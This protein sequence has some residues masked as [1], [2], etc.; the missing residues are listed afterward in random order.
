MLSKQ[1]EE[2]DEILKSKSDT[3]DEQGEQILSLQDE[4]TQM[5]SANIELNRQCQDLNEENENLQ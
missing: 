2:K 1:N 4:L 3:M 5:N